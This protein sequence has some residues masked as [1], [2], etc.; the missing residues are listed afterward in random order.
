M[1]PRA[2]HDGQDLRNFWRPRLS[3]GLNYLLNY[4][5]SCHNIYFWHLTYSISYP[6]AILTSITHTIVCE[7]IS[8]ECVLM[9]LFWD[10]WSPL[11]YFHQSCEACLCIRKLEET[12]TRQKV[13]KLRMP[14]LQNY[15]LFLLCVDAFSEVI[16]FDKNVKIWELINRL[17]DN[18]AALKLDVA[19]AAA[20]IVVLTTFTNF[21][22]FV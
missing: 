8:K 14:M 22:N 1:W 4:S 21:G 17:F 6:L 15:S 13:H 10:R 5:R 20:R 16:L 9:I 3:N 18:T 12:E 7:A 2:V 11:V 19:V